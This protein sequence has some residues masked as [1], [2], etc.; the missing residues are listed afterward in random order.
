MVRR[1]KNYVEFI[2]CECG[3]Q[4]TRPK[5]DRDNNIRLF[6][7]GHFCRNKKRSEKSK[8]KQSESRIGKYVG[9]NHPM[10]GKTHSTDTKIKI[11]LSRKGKYTGP[12]NH[13]YGK[14]RPEIKGYK[15]PSWKGDKVGYYALHRW[16][17]NYFPKP[18]LCQICKKKPPN[19]LANI[20]GIYNRDFCNWMYMCFKCH[21]IYD[22]IIERNLKPFKKKSIARNNTG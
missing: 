16:L 22:N 14:V 18:E 1:K 8:R 13:Y 12:A 15:N 4:K 2:Y 5:Y 10:Y 6:I 9:T 11:S 7:N 21:K 19:E 20:T 17:G 3:C